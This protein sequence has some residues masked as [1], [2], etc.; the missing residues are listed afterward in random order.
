MDTMAAKSTRG[1]SEPTVSRFK[2]DYLSY[3]WEWDPDAREKA[4]DIQQHAVLCYK[5]MKVLMKVKSEL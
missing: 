5:A 2:K 4:Q 1:I 3:M